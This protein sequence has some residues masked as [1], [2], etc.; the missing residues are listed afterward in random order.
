[1]AKAKLS[2]GV[3]NGLLIAGAT[4]IASVIGGV[5]LFFHSDGQNNLQTNINGN[6]IQAGRDV[7]IIQNTNSGIGNSNATPSVGNYNT[8]I[9]NMPARNMGDGNV[10]IGPTDDHGNIMLTQSMAIGYSAHAG[11]NSI[12]I[13]AFAGAGMATNSSDNTNVTR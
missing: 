4:I 3:K 2:V 10:F 9:G 5:F 8:V 6:N 13:G 12:A 7:V 11:P 1:M